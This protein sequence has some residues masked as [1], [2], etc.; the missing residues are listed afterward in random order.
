MYRKVVIEV[1]VLSVRISVLARFFP[2]ELYHKACSWDKNQLNSNTRSDVMKFA[3][4]EPLKRDAQK[5]LILC[6]YFV[7]IYNMPV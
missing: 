4:I 1:Y 6:T 2:L 7:I 5:E 3:F